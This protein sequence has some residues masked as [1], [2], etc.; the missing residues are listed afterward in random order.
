[1]DYFFLHFESAG[2]SYFIVPGSILLPYTHEINQTRPRSQLANAVS[3]Q[4]SLEKM[5]PSYSDDIGRWLQLSKV[6]LEALKK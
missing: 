2:K 4:L 5:M 6:A 1:M 3:E